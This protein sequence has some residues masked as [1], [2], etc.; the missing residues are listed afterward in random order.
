[1]VYKKTTN[2]KQ[3]K[4]FPKVEEAE[5]IFKKQKK[6]NEVSKSRKRGNFVVFLRNGTRKP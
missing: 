3:Q 5:R 4:K 1:V 6:Q 2:F